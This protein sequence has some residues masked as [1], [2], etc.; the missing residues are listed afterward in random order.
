MHRFGGAKDVKVSIDQAEKRHC[1]IF[2]DIPKDAY[3]KGTRISATTVVR[4]ICQETGG[5]VVR[6]KPEVTTWLPQERWQ[7]RGTQQG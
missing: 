5:G 4:S 7:C 1:Y 2:K 6:S 3:F